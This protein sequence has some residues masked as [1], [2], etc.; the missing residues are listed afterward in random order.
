MSQMRFVTIRNYHDPVLA[1]IVVNALHAAGITTFPIH[2]NNSGL[3]AITQHYEVKVPEKDV[4]SALEIIEE[5][6]NL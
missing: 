4:E 3:T 2:E 5:Q 1:E 6:E